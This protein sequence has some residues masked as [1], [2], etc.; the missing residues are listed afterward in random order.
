MDTYFRYSESNKG[1]SLIGI[2]LVT[3]SF[4]EGIN[5]EVSKCKELTNTTISSDCE[6]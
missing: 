4:D 5:W 6:I 2:S 3:F 1:S